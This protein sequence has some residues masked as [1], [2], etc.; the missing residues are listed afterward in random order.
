MYIIWTNIRR[1]RKDLIVNLNLIVAVADSHTVD[2]WLTKDIKYLLSIF[3]LN[4]ITLQQAYAV[5][6]AFSLLTE[7]ARK[8]KGNLQKRRH[9]LLSIE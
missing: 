5:T 7:E 1:T 9:I 8:G 3:T 4:H 2:V 6:V